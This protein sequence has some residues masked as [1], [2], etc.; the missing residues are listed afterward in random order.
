MGGIESGREKELV[1]E[2]EEK[3]KGIYCITNAPEHIL[4]PFIEE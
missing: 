3:D 1:D 2:V 4:L